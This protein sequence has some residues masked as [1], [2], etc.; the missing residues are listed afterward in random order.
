MLVGVLGVLF[1]SVPGVPCF[2]FE[3]KLRF[4]SNDNDNDDD[5]EEFHR[6]IKSDSKCRSTSIEDSSVP[7][8]SA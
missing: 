2:L 7:V 4:D 1:A 6:H 3:A 5:D 8:S